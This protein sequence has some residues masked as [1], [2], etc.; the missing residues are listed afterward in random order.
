MGAVV[1]DR[2]EQF[3]EERHHAGERVVGA[4]RVQVGVGQ[5]DTGD[6]LRLDGG[7]GAALPGLGHHVAYQSADRALGHELLVGAPH[8]AGPLGRVGPRLQRQPWIAHTVIVP[9]VHSAAQR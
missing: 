1:G 4:V 5:I 9:P 6:A 7:S 3:T 8:L 2:A